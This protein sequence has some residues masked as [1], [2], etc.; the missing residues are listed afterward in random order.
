[1]NEA[2]NRFE[3]AVTRMELHAPARGELL[4]LRAMIEPLLADPNSR[5]G[6]PAKSE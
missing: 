2:R 4:R 6:Q 1:M 5:H 3:Q